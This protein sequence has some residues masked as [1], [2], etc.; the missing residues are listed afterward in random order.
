M[1]NEKPDPALHDRLGRWVAAGLIDAD[2][3]ARIEAAERADRPR[4]TRD[5]R[6]PLVVEALGYLGGALAVIAGFL[7]VNEFWPDI[8]T[9][10]E[11]AFAAAGAAVL[12]L[13]GAAVPTGR[14][15]ALERLRGVLWLLSTAC[16][17]AFTG[18]L[19]AKVWHLEPTSTGTLASSAAAVYGL[20]LW[21]R[22]RSPLQHLA[23]FAALAV[24]VGCGISR[25]DAD[26][27]LWGPGLGVWG[28]SALWGL[29]AYKDLVP[30]RT[31]GLIAAAAGLLVGAQLTMETAAGHVLALMTVAG[32]VTAGVMARRVWLVAFGAYGIVQI[33]PQTVARYL[34]QSAAAPIAVFS[35]GVVLLGAALW[36]ARHRGP[37][38][39]LPRPPKAPSEPPEATPDVHRTRRIGHPTEGKRS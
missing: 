19:G 18:L 35:A 39:D 28:L 1:P 3:A 14:D 33:L 32:L 38:Q 13:T 29:A 27:V 31:V 37:G 23:V 21:R 26:L 5:G 8:P 9:V 16:L 36:L 10:A 2:Q 30:P 34:P 24:A 7:A 12:L 22:T 17:A 25:A 15:P 11:L 20:L 4:G 6:T